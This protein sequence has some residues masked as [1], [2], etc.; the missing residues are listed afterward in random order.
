MLENF[1][2]KKQKLLDAYAKL[3]KSGLVFSESWMV[4]ATFG[5]AFMAIGKTMDI[6]PGLIAGMILSGKS[7]HIC[8]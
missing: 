4:F 6:N 7:Q 1:N 8:R 5:I 3:A 2:T